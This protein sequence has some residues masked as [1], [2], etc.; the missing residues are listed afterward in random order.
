MTPSRSLHMKT[1]EKTRSFMKGSFSYK[2]S[3]INTFGM[4]INNDMK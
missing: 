1:D 4:V 3:D 2:T